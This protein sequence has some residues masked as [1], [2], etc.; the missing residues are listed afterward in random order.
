[1]LVHV[2]APVSGIGGNP[3]FLQEITTMLSIART[4]RPPPCLLFC[5]RVLH[6]TTARYSDKMGRME[7]LCKSPLSPNCFNRKQFATR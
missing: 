2:G 6:S 5:R 7:L 1:M 3:N 4:M